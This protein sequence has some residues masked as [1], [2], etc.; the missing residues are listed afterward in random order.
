[1]SAPDQTRDPGHAAVPETGT[2]ATGRARAEPAKG[3][4]PL[5]AELLWQALER[6]EEAVLF[7]EGDS[8]LIAAANAAGRRWLRLTSEQTRPTLAEHLAPQSWR[9]LANAVAAAAAEQLALKPILL[10][11]NRGRESL[12]FEFSRHATAGRELWIGVSR[13]GA[14]SAESETQEQLDAYRDEVTGLANRRALWK[15]YSQGLPAD[16]FS[17]AEITLPANCAAIFIDLDD[18]KAINDEHGHTLGDDILAE[19]ARNLA[20]CLR[21]GDF[22]GRYGG[23]E[24]LVIIDGISDQHLVKS[25]AE[26]IL[27]ALARPI[28]KQDRAWRMA[29][30]IGVALTGDA[31]RRLEETIAAADRAMYRAKSAGGQRV[32]WERQ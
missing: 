29:A 16:G 7:V 17:P 24:F 18:F 1:M 6:T 22:V 11:Q 28:Q 13:P 26:R 8:G 32:A 21:P 12:E 31:G 19:V 20:D 4:V 9:D 25:I 14:A 10:L 30:S 5:D 27:A 23:D 15:R 2:A 3:Q